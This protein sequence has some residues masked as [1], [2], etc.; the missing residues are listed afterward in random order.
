MFLDIVVT[1]GIFKKEVVV[2]RLTGQ[3]RSYYVLFRTNCY[4]L[5]KN[6]EVLN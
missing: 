6:K 1:N 3:Q 2:P 5:N 4:I